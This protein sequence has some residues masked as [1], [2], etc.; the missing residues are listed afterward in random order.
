MVYIEPLTLIYHNPNPNLFR[1]VLCFWVLSWGVLDLKSTKFDQFIL[2][3]I[4]K[5]VATRCQISRLKCTK[6]DFGWGSAPDPNGE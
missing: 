6:F 5:I 1:T 2:S 4:T 3:K